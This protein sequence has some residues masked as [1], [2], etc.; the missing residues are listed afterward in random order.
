MSFFRGERR[1]FDL[2]FL[3]TNDCS[4]I[5]LRYFYGAFGICCFWGPFLS[6]TG[7]YKLLLYCKNCIPILQTLL[8]YYKKITVY[9]FEMT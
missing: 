4:W 2:D 7:H 9:R 5:V 8:L 1:N 3:T 6:L